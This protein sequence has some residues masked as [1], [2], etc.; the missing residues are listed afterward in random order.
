MK[1]HLIML[2]ALPF[3]AAG[4][5]AL[6]L[7]A[8]DSAKD[9]P[10]VSADAQQHHDRGW[11]LMQPPLHHGK[12]DTSAQLADWYSIGFFDKSAQCD[13]ARARGL[14]A[15]PSYVQVSSAARN[16]IEM[17]Q[18]LATS[19]LCVPSDDPRINWFHLNW[20]WK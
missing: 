8:G 12:P 2:I 18:R 5:T 20:K 3:L 4:C 14:S 10:T 1:S 7:P 13:A 11:Y 9:S 15:Y 6:R 19:S 16:T 17:S